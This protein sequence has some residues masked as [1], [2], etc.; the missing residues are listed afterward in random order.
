MQFEGHPKTLLMIVLPLLKTSSHAIEA[1]RVLAPVYCCCICSTVIFF[2]CTKLNWCLLQLISS[3]QFRNAGAPFWK[4]VLKQFDD[5]LVKILIAAALISFI[6]A[7]INGETGL[8]AFLEPSVRLMCTSVLCLMFFWMVLF[9]ER[10]IFYNGFMK[11]H[12]LIMILHKDLK[13]VSFQ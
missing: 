7:L 3:C 10:I 11:L 2:Q 8:M 5:L 1:F 9:R 12:A 6:L 13:V 4:L